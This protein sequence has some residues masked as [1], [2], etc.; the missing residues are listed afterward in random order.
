M[1][2]G[3]D[4]ELFAGDGSAIELM[5]MGEACAYCDSCICYTKLIQSWAN[6]SILWFIFCKKY[7]YPEPLDDPLHLLLKVSEE[8]GSIDM[9][10]YSFG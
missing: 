7:I 2:V 10:K 6:I 3:L 9:N 5:A 4:E 1:S 8:V